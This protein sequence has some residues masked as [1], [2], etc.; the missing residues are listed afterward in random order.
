MLFDPIDV[1]YETITDGLN[2]HVW[3]T[4]SDAEVLLLED[5]PVCQRQP[6]VLFL[7]ALN[8]LCNATLSRKK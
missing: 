8:T 2:K 4:Y 7:T 3:N 5:I 1:C 6:S